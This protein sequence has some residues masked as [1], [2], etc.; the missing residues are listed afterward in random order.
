[1]KEAQTRRKLA[2]QTKLSADLGQGPAVSSCQRESSG[3]IKGRDFIVRLGNISNKDALYSQT[4]ILVK[5]F[6]CKIISFYLLPFFFLFL[7]SSHLCSVSI[8]EVSFFLIPFPPFFLSCS[9]FFLTRM[10]SERH[11]SV[12]YYHQKT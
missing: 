10:T 3:S 7:L 5:R 8:F 11:I 9:V 2:V 6:F 12:R 1:M 4:I